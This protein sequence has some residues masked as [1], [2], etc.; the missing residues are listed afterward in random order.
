MLNCVAV[1]VC[2][3][4]CAVGCV[5]VW[6]T[7]VCVCTCGV[8]CA[9]GCVCVCVCVCVC[10]CV[11]VCTCSVFMCVCV[12]VCVCVCLC[13]CNNMCA[14]VY[15]NWHKLCVHKLQMSSDDTSKQAGSTCATIKP[16]IYS[17]K[18]VNPNN[19]GGEVIISDLEVPG[20]PTSVD[21]L[22]NEVCKQ[23]SKYIEGYD[24]QF[25]YITPGH[26]MK[27]K[28]EKLD[29]DAELAALYS[30]HQKRKRILLWLKCKAR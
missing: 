15:V 24:T 4:C 7:C 28:Q 22:K 9:V 29:T 21:E 3:V 20:Q 13:V 6:C 12:C 18:I 5:C 27:G 14:C 23:V 30:K 25:G 16:A 10:M 1:W 2:A 8:C 11:L 26:G 19:A 17:L